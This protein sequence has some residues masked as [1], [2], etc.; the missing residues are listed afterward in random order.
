M[1]L[2]RTLI[3]LLAMTLI[4]TLQPFSPSA[5]SSDAP[6]A[7]P[8]ILGIS[9]AALYFT[10]LDAERAFFKD[11][12]GFD[13]PYFAN[14]PDGSLKLTWIKINDLQQIEL[15]PAKNPGDDRLYQLALITSDCE[16]MRHYLK[17]KGWKVPEKPVGSGQIGNHN[18]T[19]KDPDGHNIEFVEYAGT[20]WTLKDKGRHM[21]PSRISPRIRHVGIKVAD[22]AAS[23]HFYKD[24]LGCE[25]IWRGSRDNKLLSW[26]HVRLPDSDEY[27][28]L[29]LYNGPE[30]KA[31]TLGTMQH[32][33]LEVPDVQAA[34]D[35][36]Q[37]RPL[38]AA[39]KQPLSAPKT[40]INGKRQINIYDPEGTRF[41]LMEPGT[42]DGNPVPSSDAPLPV[43]DKPKQ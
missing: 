4:S 36:L 34:Y 41:E 15:F 40:G 35:T 18:M 29:M 1:K 21:P 42:H 7:R 31:A 27:I 23:L 16:A 2:T 30:P 5:F 43:P 19:V 20:G 37:K 3:P 33:S 26:V 38:P 10:N 32:I 8:K 24:I 6:P 22:L 25:E 11:Y 12:L 17:S 13:E 28:E 14:N 39:C 9:H